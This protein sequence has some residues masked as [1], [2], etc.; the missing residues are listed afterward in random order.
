MAAHKVPLTI[1]FWNKVDKSF[2]HGPQGDCWV[3]IADRCKDGYGSIKINK[4]TSRSHRVS[5]EIHNG[6]I[7]DSL[8]VLHKCDNPPCVNP[9]H[10]FLGTVRDNVDDMMRKGRTLKG[11][12]H[13]SH[14]NPEAWARGERV[15]TAVLTAS[16]VSEILIALKNG[17]G[18]TELGRKYGVLK[19]AIYSIREGRTWKHIPRP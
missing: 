17:A 18:L 1:R 8:W 5:W 2:G 10:L 15:N 4:K 19:H 16:Q 9:D 14:T 13:P 7:P 3:W 11:L 12:N 6:P